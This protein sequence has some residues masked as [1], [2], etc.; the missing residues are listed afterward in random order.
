MIKELFKDP[1]ALTP[2]I[3][4]ILAGLAGYAY[5]TSSQANQARIIEVVDK[6]TTA[7]VRL[8]ATTNEM[9]A[10]LIQVVGNRKSSSELIESIRA[11]ALSNATRVAATSTQR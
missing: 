3:G 4:F 1:K 6:N 8:E 11:V 10:L 7:M 9:R 2:I 5:F